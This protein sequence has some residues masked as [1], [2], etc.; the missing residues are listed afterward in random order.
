VRDGWLVQLFSTCQHDFTKL[1]STLGL[2]FQIR[3]DYAN[4]CS[5][6]VRMISLGDNGK[7][8]GG[9]VSVLQIYF[10]G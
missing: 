1:S 3:D 8:V 6:E 5:Q 7:R 9:K 10:S 2:Y 4:L